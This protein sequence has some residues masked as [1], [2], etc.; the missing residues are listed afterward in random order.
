MRRFL[1]EGALRARL[2][3]GALRFAGTFSW[4]RAADETMKLI[5]EAIAERESA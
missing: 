2:T 5:E 4:D 1:E 3:E